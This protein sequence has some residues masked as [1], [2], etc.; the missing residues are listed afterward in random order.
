[1]G[2]RALVVGLGVTGRAVSRVL[3]A[4]DWD[5][6]VLEERIDEEKQRAAAELGVRLVD[7][8][9]ESI[10][11]IA[12]VVP[13]PGVPAA[14]HV[15][16]AAV[17]AGVPVRS[18]IEL[19]WQRAKAPLVAIT[20]TNGKTTVTTLVT[21]MLQTAGARVVAAGNIGLPL[22]EAVAQD[23]DVVVAEVSS[24]QLR[25]T[26]RFRPAIG[27]WLNFA[28]DHLDWHPTMGHYAAA[29]ARLW[30]N[31]SGSDLAV[32]N[33]D[34]A[35]VRHALS[36]AKG[37]TQTFGSGAGA[38]WR[39]EDGT[40]VGPPGAV[41]A[42][43]ELPRALPHDIENA[44]AACATAVGAGAPL[45]A[46]RTVLRR[47]RGLP[48][49]VE[50]VGDAG[51]VRFYDDSKA[52]TPASVLAA[53]RGFPSVVL[54]AG[55][56]NKG[57]DLGVLR[58]EA[59]RIRAVVAIGDA[60]EE[61]MAAFRGAAPVQQASTMDDAV[62]LAR[63]VARPGD[64]VLLSPGCASFD[65]YGSYAERGDDFRRAVREQVGA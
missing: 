55:G 45:E 37:R 4:D 57:L 40:L 10:G 27:V 25:Y 24:F 49:R 50:L 33:A 6:V 15:F 11:P 34:D 13:S 22:V 54:V 51:G 59:T 19:A 5:V 12:L 21:E 32:G 14:H 28:E 26:E 44:L 41:L 8:V 52:T 46:C 18:E 42:T 35:V 29:K 39:C 63:A 17:R 53:L 36:G 60:A 20:G 61:V 47:F 30:A 62:R 31:Q 1:M 48:H 43:A 64:A 23:L 56:R 7:T 58:Q 2:V 9:D 38:D 65:W 16:D 3:R